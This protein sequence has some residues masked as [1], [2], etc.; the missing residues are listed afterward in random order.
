LQ[1]HRLDALTDREAEVLR[2]VARG[3]S[4]AEVA[5]TLFLESAVKTHVGTS[6]RSSACATGSRR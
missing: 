4:N 6:S 5:G 2:L 3:M 1:T